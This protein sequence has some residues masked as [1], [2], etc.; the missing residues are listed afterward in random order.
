MTLNIFQS[1]TFLITYTGNK[2]VRDKYIQFLYNLHMI[3][4]TYASHA[5]KHF[6]AFFD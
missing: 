1:F 3:L 2:S 5:G 6:V 4:I